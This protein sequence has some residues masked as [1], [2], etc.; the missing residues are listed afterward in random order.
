MRYAARRAAGVG[1]EVL[2]VSVLPSPDP[3]EWG[4]VRD[5][6]VADARDKAQA[7]LD[8][9]A[10]D[11]AEWIGTRP[12]TRIVEGEVG[13]A[14][15]AAL[16]AEGERAAL[17]LGA[18]AKGAPGPLVAWFTGERAGSLPCPVVIVPGGLSERDI[19]ALA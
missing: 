10:D 8:R 7:L 1:G 6:I 18:A 14:V 15:L 17:V 3:V 11:A 9:A 2:L 4:A 19:D 12:R 13:P 16:A 5:A